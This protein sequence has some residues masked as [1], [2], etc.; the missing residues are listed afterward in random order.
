L[1]KSRYLGG[2]CIVIKSKKFGL[3]KSSF[4]LRRKLYGIIFFTEFSYFLLGAENFIVKKFSYG[5][6]I[7]ASRLYGRYLK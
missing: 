3:L 7:T 5:R 4:T 1:G 2:D 6:K